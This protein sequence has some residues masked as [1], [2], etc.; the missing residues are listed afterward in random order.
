VVA[1]AAVSGSAQSFLRRAVIHA[2][3]RTVHVLEPPQPDSAEADSSEP[4]STEP[5]APIA[6][7]QEPSSPGATLPGTETPVD[8]EEQPAEAS[9]VAEPPPGAPSRFARGLA[10]GNFTEDRQS[11]S[12]MLYER[13]SDA[14]VAAIQTAI[15]EHPDLWMLAEATTLDERVPLILSYG[16]WLDHPAII[17]NTG[18]SAA[19]PPEEVHAMARGALAAAGGLYEADLIVNALSSAGVEMKDVASALDFGC[20]SG[21]VLRVLR[22]AFPETAWHGCDPN[23]AAVTWASQ[24][25]PDIEFFVNDDAPPLPLAD[26]SLDLAYAISIWSHFAPE[27]G[28]LWFEEMHRLL[29]PGGQLVMTTHGMASVGFYAT[30]SLRM[31]QQSDEILGALY[32][33]GWWYAPEFG[34]QGD[35]GVV[36]PDWGTAF[37]SPEWVLTQLCPRWRVLEFAPGRNQNNQDVYVL[38]RV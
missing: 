4:G 37:L 3:R 15:D 16:A 13:L 28:L 11:V 14:D 38:R 6:A 12:R 33:E 5:D 19:Q 31:P 23:A 17:T 30:N 24:N 1:S 20:S 27:L 9:P 34:E 36:N 7:A 8:E 22:A 35:W 25:L 10:P 21:R 18:L 32:R 26:G 2:A 29:R